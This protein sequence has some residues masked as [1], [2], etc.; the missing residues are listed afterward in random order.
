MENRT[1]SDHAVNGVTINMILF[2]V[3]VSLENF[4][5]DPESAEIFLVDPVKYSRKR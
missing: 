4:A 1:L 2:N 5:R 3:I